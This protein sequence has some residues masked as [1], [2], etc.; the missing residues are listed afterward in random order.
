MPLG[1][2]LSG[3]LADALG[4]HA[5]LLLLSGLGVL[6][7][8]LW[9]ATP[10]VRTLRRPEPA[11]EE[12]RPRRGLAPARG[13]R[14]LGLPALRPVAPGP[15]SA[16]A[17]A[18]VGVLAPGLAARRSPAS[19]APRR[20][21]PPAARAGSVAARRPPGTASPCSEPSRRAR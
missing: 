10:S 15:A 1:L 17:L 16:T 7:A 4:L 12:R 11:A 21:G 20:P 19:D 18:G 6:S 3:P 14:P 5:T 2:A 8:L 9:L 13:A